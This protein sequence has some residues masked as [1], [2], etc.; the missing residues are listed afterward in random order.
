MFTL[1]HSKQKFYQQRTGECRISDVSRYLLSK[2]SRYHV[3]ALCYYF[4]SIFAIFFLSFSVSILK[5]KDVVRLAIKVWVFFIIFP[6]IQSFY[7]CPLN[8]DK[9]I[10]SN[11]NVSL[12]QI[13]SV[14]NSSILGLFVKEPTC[15]KVNFSG[16][17]PSS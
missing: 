10:E 16:Q 8:G 1:I 3:I 17:Q 13:Q 15:L 9:G 11:G 6:I 2:V 14:K 5:Q 7:F 4:C 12:V